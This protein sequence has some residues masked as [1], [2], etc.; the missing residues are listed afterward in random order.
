[1]QNI[2]LNVRAPNKESPLKNFPR[3]AR[4][5]KLVGAGLFVVSIQP[6]ERELQAS[7]DD[8]AGPLMLE[9]EPACP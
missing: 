5:L 1:M 7:N 9:G 6:H 2:S 3:G 8:H 4:M